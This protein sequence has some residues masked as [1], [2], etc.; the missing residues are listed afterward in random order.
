MAFDYSPATVAKDPT[1]SYRQTLNLPVTEFPMKADLARR[2]PE[3]LA[4]WKQSGL[5]DRILAARAGGPRFVMHDGPPYA[6]GNIHYGHILNKIL[7]DLVVKYRTMTG[8]LAVYKPGWDTH[9]LPIEL[10][11][12]R[13][14]GDK[15]ASMSKLDIRAACH[16]HAM[17]YVDIQRTEFQRLGIFGT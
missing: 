2:E 15:K 16:A 3:M 7:K 14:L 11:V 1:D 13:S 6:N 10:Q 8:A 17:K 12:D 5:Y 4:A 9:G